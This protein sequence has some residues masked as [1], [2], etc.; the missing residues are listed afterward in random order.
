MATFFSTVS[1]LF[2]IIISPLVESQNPIDSCWRTNPKW[3]SNRRALAGC[4][5]GFGKYAA[6]GKD[7]SI[8]V[9]TSSEDDPENP[10]P[11]TLRHA[12]IQSDP[13]W[14]TFAGDMSIVL[15]NELIMNSDK[16][17]DGR[18]AKVEISNG[19]CITIQHVSHVIIHGISI[20]HC[21]P[22]K[23][24]LVR[25]SP[26]HIGR[27]GGSDGD[28]ISVFNSSNVW[29]DHCYF[30]RSEDGLIDVVLGS[31]AVTISNNYF[32]QHHKVM[33]LGHND[34]SEVDE[35]MKVTIAF[36]YFGSGLS[37][38]IPRVR[39]GYAHVANNRY[40]K[41]ESYAIGGSADPT[42][43]SE[44]NYF[45]APDDPSKKQVTK[46]LESGS[47]RK[48]WKWISSKDV[49]LNGAYFEPSSNGAVMS[50]YVKEE[51]FSVYDGSL[52][53]NLT[54]SAGPLSC[55]SGKIC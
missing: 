40:D 23:S 9:V 24:G 14:I 38:R 17:I 29:I 3:D 47:D 19:P 5:V 39:R 21:K 42:I 36:N 35:R 50:L 11:G 43:F 46:R 44:G 41:W 34:N 12:V 27:R 45:V 8:Y 16:T 37:E 49:L 31:T 25:S 52:V 1:L 55:Y 53:P 54:S 32:T 2:A 18:G 33:L 6:G 7:G 20:H 4:A 13:L 28:A 10:R 48:S 15:K 22:G 26:D 30:S 51:E